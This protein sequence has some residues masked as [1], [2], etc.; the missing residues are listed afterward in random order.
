MLPQLHKL[1]LSADM[2]F[3]YQTLECNYFDKP[4]HFHKEY[5]LVLIDRSEGTRFIGDNVSQFKD[6]DLTL[7]GSN[8]PH[9]FRNDEEF[10]KENPFLISKSIFIHFTDGFMGPDF[11]HVPEMRSVLNLLSKSSLALEIQGKTKKNVVNILYEMK[12]ANPPKRLLKLFEILICIS[13]SKETRQLLSV[14]FNNNNNIKDADKINFAFQF[15]IKNY[16]N[17]IYIDDIASSLNMSITAFS[18]YFKHHTRKTFTEYVTEIRI[19]NAC[20]LLMENNH[21]ISEICNMCGFDN[22]SNFYR[23]F[24]KNIGV[25]PKEYR[26]R[27]LKGAE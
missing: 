26:K 6:G 22:E 24:K 17:K 25:V 18:R 5:E 20:R 4:W 23:H 12:D 3:I 14:G 11:F 16:K 10:Y 13:E 2:S 21:T 1:P 19:G 7:I 8:I 27:F 9:L 15:I